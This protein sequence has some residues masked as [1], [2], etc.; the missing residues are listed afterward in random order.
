MNLC[1]IPARGG[2]KR[3]K[4]K[5]IKMFN[6]KPIIAYSIEAALKSKCFS[7]VIVSTDDNEIAEVAEKFGAYV[8]F[9]RPSN[10]SNDFAGT[11]PVV[12]HAIN[13]MEKNNNKFDNVCCLYA[14][15][16]FLRPDIISKAYEQLLKSKKDYC[17]SVTSY[18]FMIQRA[19]KISQDNKINMFY[20][21]YFNKRSQDLDEAFHDAG[22]F[23]W[24]KPKAFKD[25][26]PIFS[27][28]SSPFILPRHLVQDIDTMEDWIRAEIMFKVLLE[29]EEIL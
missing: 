3:I 20:P 17:F 10:L 11:I 2:S 16:P 13:W 29:T 8:P 9:V 19:I 12:K 18:A 25:E 23:Y 15:A 6:G 14:T 22:Q 26:L 27:E 4:H 5:N 28:V 24:G 21:E 1:V 7:K